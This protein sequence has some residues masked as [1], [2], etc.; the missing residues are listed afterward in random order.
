VSQTLEL[1]H[2]DSHS[3]ADLFHLVD[4]TGL[5]IIMLVRHLSAC[6][7]IRCDN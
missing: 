5:I 6:K 4:L 1:T 2:F 7:V 3:L